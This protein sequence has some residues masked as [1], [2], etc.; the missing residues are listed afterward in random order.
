MYRKY[1]EDRFV[2]VDLAMF[3]IFTKASPQAV[4][5]KDFLLRTINSSHVQTLLKVLVHART[6]NKL[7][8]LSIISDLVE[9]GV[10]Y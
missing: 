9:I 1:F 2:N 6:N 10:P 8:I 7:T 5:L 3:K 4:N